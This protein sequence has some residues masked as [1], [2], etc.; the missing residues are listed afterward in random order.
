MVFRVT[1][2][3]QVRIRSRRRRLYP[4]AGIIDK[5]VDGTEPAITALA[6]LVEQR[7]P[8]LHQ[9]RSESEEPGPDRLQASI[10]LGLTAADPG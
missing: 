7:I 4:V 2:T 1:T 3:N 5:A 8:G 9:F 10:D 6:E